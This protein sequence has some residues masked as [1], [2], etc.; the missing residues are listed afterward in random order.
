M[1]AEL[2]G[3]VLNYT[4]EV[5][6]V[7]FPLIPYIPFFLSKNRTKLFQQFN[8]G[9]CYVLLISN[10]LRIAFYIGKPYQTFLLL[11]SVVLIIEM[12][13]LLVLASICLNTNTENVFGNVIALPFGIVVVGFFFRNYILFVQI[14]G[15]LASIVEV[16][17]AIPQIVQNYKRKS[18]DGIPYL[19][20]LLWMGGDAVKTIY[21]CISKV[22]IQ[23]VLCGVVQF[24]CDVIVGTQKVF[25]TEKVK[26]FVELCCSKCTKRKE[27]EQLKEIAMDDSREEIIAICQ[28]FTN[29]N[30]WQILK[31]VKI[32]QV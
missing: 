24:L 30:G 5:A 13:L 26:H 6:M 25:Y 7:L 10:F 21:Y 9:V 29:R 14:V 17:L 1:R 18:G 2:I 11:Q 8:S 20:I 32:C 12:I 19:T 31:K 3:V 15:T 16:T 4:I 28:N 22:P 23:F 27:S